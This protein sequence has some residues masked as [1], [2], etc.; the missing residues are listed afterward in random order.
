MKHL[1][2]STDH[3]SVFKLPSS[4]STPYNLKF[5]LHFRVDLMSHNFL[6]SVSLTVPKRPGHRNPF[7]GE[8]YRGR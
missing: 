7:F 3:T 2:V 1:H 6:A 4:K 5:K 8:A